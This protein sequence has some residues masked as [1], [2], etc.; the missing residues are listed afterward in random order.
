[1]LDLSQNVCFAPVGSQCVQFSRV[2]NPTVIAEVKVKDK[3][4]L[5]LKQSP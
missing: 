1:M 4:V 2:W 5:A 3:V